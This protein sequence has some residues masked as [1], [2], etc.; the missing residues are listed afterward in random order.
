MATVIHTRKGKYQYAYEHTREGDK[1]VSKYMHP[2]D[3]EGN[4]RV[5]QHREQKPKEKVQMR[6]KNFII[7]PFC[8]STNIKYVDT[9]TDIRG[10]GR[11]ETSLCKD[12]GALAG[13]DT[14]ELERVAQHEQI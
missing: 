7:C 4:K 12:C 8:G 6:V 3:A 5:A 11:K 10:Y 14:E 9:T 13:H 2:V 1:V